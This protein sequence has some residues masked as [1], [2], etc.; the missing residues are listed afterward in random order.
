MA[1]QMHFKRL[2]YQIQN[3][4]SVSLIFIQKSQTLLTLYLVYYVILG[5]VE[6]L[7]VV[8]LITVLSLCTHS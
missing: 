4:Y 8:N 7:N 6:V 2:I 3:H 1:D 5:L